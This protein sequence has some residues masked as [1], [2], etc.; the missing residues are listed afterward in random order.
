MDARAARF[1]L[2]ERRASLC[3]RGR[4]ARQLAARLLRPLRPPCGRSRGRPR[5]HR[6]DQPAYC[7]RCRRRIQHRPRKDQP[8]SLRVDASAYGLLHGPFGPAG[9]CP[10]LCGHSRA[11]CRNSRMAR[12]SGQPQLGRGVDR[13][14][15][16][17][18]GV[19]FSGKTRLRM[20]FCRCGTGV[21]R[22]PGSRHFRRFVPARG[23]LVS[24]GVERGFARGPRRERHAALPRPLCRLCR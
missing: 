7:R 14:P 9:R 23:R 13:R 16:A 2:P 24:D 15:L 17:F 3:R 8:E 5:R 4:G 11:L 12:R 20:V 6:L 18:H 21:A 19:L 22:R 10:A 1:G